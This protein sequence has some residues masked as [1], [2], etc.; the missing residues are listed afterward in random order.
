MEKLEINNLLDLNQTIAKKIFENSKYPWEIIQKI[1]D[2]II[3][4]GKSLDKEKFEEI[5]ENIWV[6][7]SASIAKTA[8]IQGPCIIDEEAEIRHSAFIRG[9]V[10]IGKKVVVRKFFR[11][12]KYNYI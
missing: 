9:N 4:L 10:I 8:C 5:E 6:A 7:K 11:I 3:E 12:K 1:K 2:F